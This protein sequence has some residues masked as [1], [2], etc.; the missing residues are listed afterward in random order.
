MLWPLNS[1]DLYM[2]GHIEC[3]YARTALVLV[4]VL[5][6]IRGTTWSCYLA[7]FSAKAKYDFI[8]I[9]DNQVI[10]LTVTD[11]YDP[12]YDQYIWYI[13]TISMTW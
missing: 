9:E 2:V 12:M 7:L 13:Y 8:D 3:I 1:K 10:P 6:T 11:T 5:A 4:I